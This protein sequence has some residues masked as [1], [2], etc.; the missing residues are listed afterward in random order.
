MTHFERHP[1]VDALPSGERVVL[2]HCE[3]RT[4]LV[5]NPTASLLWNAL[6]GAATPESLAGALQQK[7]PSVAPDQA[8]ADAQKLLDDLQERGFLVRRDDS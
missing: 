1:K 6:D 8:R 4:A 2:Y 5:L 7:F 3:S